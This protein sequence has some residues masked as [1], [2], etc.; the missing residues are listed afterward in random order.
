M[1]DMNI[2]SEEIKYNKESVCAVTVFYYADQAA[3]DNARFLADLVGQAVVVV[4]GMRE[5][6]HKLEEK[7]LNLNIK[8]IYNSENMGIAYALNQG[9]QYAMQNG[10]DF[11]LTMDQDSGLYQDSVEQLLRALDQHRELT[12]VCCN[13]IGTDDNLD[14]IEKDTVI[15]SGNLTYTKAIEDVNG[16]TEKLFID[17]VDL[18]FSLK[19]REMGYRIAV[20]PTARIKHKIGDIKERKIFGKTIAISHHSPVRYYYMARN[21]RYFIHR[22]RKTFPRVCIKNIIVYMYGSVLALLFESDRVQVYKMKMRG[23]RDARRDVYGAYQEYC[24]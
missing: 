14:F 17:C 13:Y 9:V 7:F 11:V 2:R 3:I 18:D 6:D 22:F 5:S 21:Y 23:R 1:K 10:F 4:N 19:L 15:T 8:L 20:I 24:G 16:F 12:S